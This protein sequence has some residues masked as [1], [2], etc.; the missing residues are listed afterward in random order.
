MDETHASKVA[1]N[2][3]YIHTKKLYQ[4]Y[5]IIILRVCD[6]GLFLL[7]V[8]LGTNKQIVTFLGSYWFL[9]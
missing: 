8:Y 1:K 3:F 2:C 7:G 9:V 6:Q 4:F 5:E